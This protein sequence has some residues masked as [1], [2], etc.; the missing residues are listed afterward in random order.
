[1]IIK[2][3]MMLKKVK[4]AETGDKRSADNCWKFYLQARYDIYIYLYISLEGYWTKVHKYY[5]K[6]YLI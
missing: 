2:A 3:A 1:M 4:K 6:L 5:L